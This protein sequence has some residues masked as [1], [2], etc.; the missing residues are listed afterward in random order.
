MAVNWD[1]I[2]ARLSSRGPD[3]KFLSAVTGEETDGELREMA[4]RFTDKCPANQ[5]RC[6]CPFRSLNHH[7]HV[8]VKALVTGMTRAALLSLFELECEVRNTDAVA[9][10]LQDGGKLSHGNHEE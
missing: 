9:S 4:I 6:H 8:S 1:L 10:C 3:G 2:E 7:Y 5:Q